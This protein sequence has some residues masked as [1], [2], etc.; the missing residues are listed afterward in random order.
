LFSYPENPKA[1]IVTA[2]KVDLFSPEAS[3]DVRRRALSI[4][5]SHQAGEFVEIDHKLGD[6]LMTEILRREP[7]VKQNCSNSR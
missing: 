2:A 7:F 4:V 5:M 1:A 3:D 6:P